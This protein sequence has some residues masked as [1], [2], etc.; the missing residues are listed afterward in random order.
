MNPDH[1]RDFPVQYL[2]VQ[3]RETAVARRTVQK[4]VFPLRLLSPVDRELETGGCSTFDFEPLRGSRKRAAAA[5]S[6]VLLLVL[7]LVEDLPSPLPR[8]FDATHGC[9]P[10]RAS[11]AS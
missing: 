9:T 5:L 8:R 2:V 7:V 4:I 10:D 11:G 3:K 6:V 1:K